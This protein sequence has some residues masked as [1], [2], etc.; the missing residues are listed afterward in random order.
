MLAAF[1][2]HKS[3]LGLA[4]WF[5]SVNS[6]LR[7]KRPQDLLISDPGRV[8]AAAEHDVIGLLHG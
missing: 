6:F 8:V 7:G 1:R 2:G 5:A 4:Y 3:D